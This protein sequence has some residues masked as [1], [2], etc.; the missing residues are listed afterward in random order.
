MARRGQPLLQSESKNYETREVSETLICDLVTSRLVLTISYH[1]HYLLAVAD[2]F[3]IMRP[4]F[5]TDKKM[6]TAKWAQGGRISV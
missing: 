1:D 3:S 4:E 2:C 6:F 5:A